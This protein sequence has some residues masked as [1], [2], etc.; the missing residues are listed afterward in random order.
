[1]GDDDLCKPSVLSPIAEDSLLN[2]A[3]DDDDE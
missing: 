2:T 1:M 3:E